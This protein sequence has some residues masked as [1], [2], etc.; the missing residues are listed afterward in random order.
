MQNYIS[1]GTGGLYFKQG[2]FGGLLNFQMAQPKHNDNIVI[3]VL[4]G[5]FENLE[6]DFIL[7][8]KALFDMFI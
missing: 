1:L 2:N 3:L 6:L 4:R 7:L 8:I 5:V